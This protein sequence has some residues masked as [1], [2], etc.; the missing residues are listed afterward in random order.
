MYMCVEVK[1]IEKGTQA[2]GAQT[3]LVWKVFE[4][5]MLSV[6]ILHKRLLGY[7]GS[8]R[9]CCSYKRKFRKC[10]RDNVTQNLKDKTWDQGMKLIYIRFMFLQYMKNTLLN[11]M[12]YTIGLL[13]RKSKIYKKHIITFNTIKRTGCPIS[14]RFFMLSQVLYTFPF[15]FF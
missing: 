6:C 11:K 13:F 1:R 5:K 9:R 14:V 12:S 15:Y 4:S 8:S 2:K 10:I 3:P 7:L